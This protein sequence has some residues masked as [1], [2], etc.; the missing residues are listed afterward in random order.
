MALEQYEVKRSRRKRLTR[1]GWN[2]RRVFRGIPNAIVDALIPTYGTAWPEIVEGLAPVLMDWDVEEDDLPN[3]SRLVL[4]YKTPTWDEWLEIHAPK[5]VFLGNSSVQSRRARIVNGV[6]MEGQDPSDATGK[7]FYKITSGGTVI[8]DS[9]CI[10]R[11]HA[12]VDNIDTWYHQFTDRVGTVNNAALTHFG[13][14]FSGAQKLMLYGM[15]WTP[16]Q[17][18]RKLYTVE[19]DLLGNPEG[20]LTDVT[21]SEFEIQVVDEVARSSP[22]AEPDGEIRQ[23]KLMVPTGVTRTETAIRSTSL[24]PIDTLLTNSW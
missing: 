13:P 22:G 19:Y 11:V 2:G 15:R 4:L 21:A 9:R 17:S 18:Y 14:T 1:S 6:V 7:K 16:R 3:Q 10:M 24:Y 5:G 12:V 20:W 8:V 23:V